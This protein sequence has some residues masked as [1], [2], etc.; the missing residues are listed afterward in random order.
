LA[1]GLRILAL[2]ID[3]AF[4]FG[5]IPLVFMG[6]FGLMD[7]LPEELGILLLFFMV[8]AF[9]LIPVWPVLCLAIPTGIWGK[10]L[11]KLICRLEVTDYYDR[12]PGIWRALG[13]ETLK[14]LA[15]ASTIGAILTLFQIVYQNGT[16]YDD[17]CGT[18][19]EFKPYIRLTKTQR[20]Y[21]KYMKDR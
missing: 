14:L 10:S 7:L 21:R 20:N 2:M 6:V 16:W 12:R 11:G 15:I 13:R 5:T 17:L 1:I 18:K 4:C 19:V 9:I 3:L 8:I